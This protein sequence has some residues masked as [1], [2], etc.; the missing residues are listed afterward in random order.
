MDINDVFGRLD[1]WRGFP[2]YQLERRVDIFFAVYLRK[3]LQEYVGPTRTDIIPEF[4]IKQ[5]RSHLSDKVDYLA[6]SEDGRV[7]MLVELKTSVLGHR[8]K[9]IQYLIRAATDPRGPAG[10]LNGAEEI[11][12]VSR[13]DKYAKLKA[14][15]HSMGLL[16]G[17]QGT[18]PETCQIVFVQP[19]QDLDEV[20]LASLREPIAVEYKIIDFDMF[21][22][23]VEREPGEL[24]RRFAESLWR[25]FEAAK[26]EVSRRQERRRSN[27]DI[28]GIV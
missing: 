15:L 21:A 14:S 8:I 18:V 7:L 22:E 12:G 26:L 24:S 16:S 4:P 5:R 25:W 1:D 17:N 6:R 11:V 20:V 9:Q 3:V 28:S 23:V 27:P 13:S 2:N 19:T 10:I